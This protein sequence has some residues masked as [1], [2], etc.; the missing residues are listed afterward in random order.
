MMVMEKMEMA[1]ILYVN[2]RKDGIAYYN[3]YRDLRY[4]MN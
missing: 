3:N 2:Q 4:A 1:V